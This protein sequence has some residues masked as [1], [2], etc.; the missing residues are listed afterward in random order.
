M[1]ISQSW[2]TDKI[3]CQWST[4]AAAFRRVIDDIKRRLD[5]IAQKTAINLASVKHISS[6]SGDLDKANSFI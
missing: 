3:N 2:A 5:N 4:H 6:S 1:I